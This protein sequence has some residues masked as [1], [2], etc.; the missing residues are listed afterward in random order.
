MGINV[1]F[2]VSI[3]IVAMLAL[4]AAFANELARFA[5]DVNPYDKEAGEQHED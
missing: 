2:A 4:S 5:Q 1:K 3:A